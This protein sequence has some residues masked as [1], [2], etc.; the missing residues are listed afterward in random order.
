M[1]TKND[2]KTALERSAKALELKPSAGM[3]TKKATAKLVDGLTCEVTEE[4]YTFTS[5]M[6]KSL[7]GNDAGLGPGAF[8]RISL[9]SCLAIGYGMWLAKEEVPYEEIQVEVEGDLDFRGMLGVDDSVPPG[10]KEMRVRV[11]IASPAPQAEIERAIELADRHSPLMHLIT[12]PI[13]VIRELNLTV[14]AAVAATA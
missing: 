13:P 14:P 9:A 2:V 6:P 1:K 11:N 12:Q 8:G 7:G 3:K 10:H 5:D 4:E